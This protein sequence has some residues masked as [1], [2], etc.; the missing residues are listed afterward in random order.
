MPKGNQMLFSILHIF[1]VIF[2]FELFGFKFC[3]RFSQ[4]SYFNF[5]YKFYFFYCFF[6]HLVLQS[7]S[8]T[9]H[10]FCFC[11]EYDSAQF[12]SINNRN[13]FYN[14]QFCTNFSKFI[15]VPKFYQFFPRKF[16]IFADTH[17][18]NNK[19]LLVRYNKFYFA[20]LLLLRIF[21]NI[22]QFVFLAT[23]NCY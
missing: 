14:P 7:L 22:F 16:L 21:S 2:K 1:T 20:L 5:F 13:F 12:L 6:N 17:F 10:N 18:F 11:F 19:F 4:D 23:Y 9:L 3:I 15:L 8:I